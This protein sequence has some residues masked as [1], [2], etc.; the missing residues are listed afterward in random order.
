VEKK[1]IENY[2]LVPLTI[3]R[4]VDRDARQRGGPA[5]SVEEVREQLE[6]ILS[7]LRELSTDLIAEELVKRKEAKSVKE[8]NRGPSEGGRGLEEP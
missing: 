6:A 4:V 2:L 7:E 8:A 1:E 3:V 5:P